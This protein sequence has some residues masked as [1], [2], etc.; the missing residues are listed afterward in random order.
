MSGLPRAVEHLVVVSPERA[1]RAPDPVLLPPDVVRLAW[2]E[3]G[4]AGSRGPE[5]AARAAATAALAGGAHLTP[6]AAARMRIEAHWRPVAPDLPFVG[7]GGE[8]VIVPDAVARPMPLLPF[9]RQAV[10]TYLGLRGNPTEGPLFVSAGGRQAEPKELRAGL[11]AVGKLLGLRGNEL[12]HNLLMFFERTLDG[13]ADRIASG[14]LRG[15]Y[16]RFGNRPGPPAAQEPVRMRDLRRILEARHPLSGPARD[17]FGANGAAFVAEGVGN[18]P[19]RPR[20]ARSEL[21]EVFETDPE[22]REL[23]AAVWPEDEE[24]RKPLRKALR[25]RHFAHLHSLWREKRLKSVEIAHL[26]RCSH[27]AACEALRRIPPAGVVPV[28]RTEAEYM[29]L[30]IPRWRARPE[31]ETLP[32]FALRMAHEIGLPHHTVNAHRY[33]RQA[34]ELRRRRGRSRRRG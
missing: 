21:S 18:L 7:D 20:R 31:G 23:A 14:H 24:D 19:P 13:E 27:G 2:L 25:A 10:E 34:G 5:I 29:E 26:L 8:I 4:L 11:T 33:L 32:A 28:G 12:W 30:L 16:T 6:E 1:L 3:T 17:Y 9:V 15:R 22:V